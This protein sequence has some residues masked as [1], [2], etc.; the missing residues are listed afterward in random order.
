MAKMKARGA[1]VRQSRALGVQEASGVARLPDGSFLV[2]DDEQGVFRAW[3]DRPSER[4]AAGNGLAD[5]E[6]V[7]VTPDGSMAWLLSERDGAVWRFGLDDGQPDRGTRLGRLPRESSKKN[8]GWEGLA[9]APAGTLADEDLLVA[10]HQRGPRLVGLFEPESLAPRA[11]LS[12]PRAVKK[13]IRD[14]NDVTVHPTTG[15]IVIVSG[16]K[17][18]LAELVLAGDQLEPSRLFRVEHAKDDVPEGVTYDAEGRLWLVTD[19]EGWLRE[20]DLD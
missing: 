20:L 18:M 16:K 7:C 11:M 10:A 1:R 12:L 14:L 19:G 4:L 13:R 3:V 15:R 6:G 2:V 5:L 8:R 17:G 9:F